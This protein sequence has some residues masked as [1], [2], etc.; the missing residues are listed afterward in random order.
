MQNFDS[1]V[2]GAGQAGPALAV[3]LAKS[4]RKTAIIER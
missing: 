1:I 4:G 2:I 3:R